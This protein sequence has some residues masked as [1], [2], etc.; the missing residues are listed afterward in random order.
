MPGK[1][2]LFMG[3]EIGQRR[4]WSEE[5]EVNWWLLDAGPY[6]IGTQ[7]WVRDLN[8]FYQREPA[9]WRGDYE[10]DG[11]WWVD[12][13]D[14]GN[15]VLS[16]IRHDRES[17]HHVLA[18][19]NLTPNPLRDYRVGVPLAGDWNEVLNSDAAIYGGGNVGNG[20]VVAAEDFS[21][22]NQRYSVVLTLPPLGL[23]VFQAG[24]AGA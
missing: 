14:H 11:F 15:S 21:V 13:S 5:S 1:K 19:L 20:G 18:V 9:L 17:G 2:L 10:S 8:A 22:Q 7:N 3:G 23:V 4:E 16:F 12:C 24:A 6:H